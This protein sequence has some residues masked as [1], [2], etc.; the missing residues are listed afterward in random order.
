MKSLKIVLAVAIAI[1][2]IT[3]SYANTFDQ[4][5]R[6]GIADL[7]D[8]EDNFFGVGYQ[9]YFKDVELDHNA[10]EISSYLQRVDSINLD[11][12]KIDDVSRLQVSAEVFLQNNWVVRPRFS[13]V[14]DDDES[15]MR[16]GTDIGQF[17][18]DNWEVGAGLDYFKSDTRFNYDENDDFLFS[19]YTRYTTL[20]RNSN[21][22]K[23]GWDLELQGTVIGE[24]TSVVASAAYYFSPKFSLYGGVTQVD[25]DRRDAITAVNLG[26]NYWFNRSFSIN[27]GLG[28]DVGGDGLRSLD[29]L[30]SYRF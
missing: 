3:F 17:I 28:V 15:N 10:W 23:P 5:L 27:F 16:I 22:F 2:S 24:D 18:K 13:R 14:A 21:T 19:I 8:T 12:L 26:T 7:N 9:Y 1:S 11:Y 30:A 25:R 20:E 4:E 6:V 29:L